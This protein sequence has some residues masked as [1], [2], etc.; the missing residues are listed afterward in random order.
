MAELLGLYQPANINSFIVAIVS[1]QGGITLN[2]PKTL[3][4][5]S[6]RLSEFKTKVAAVLSNFDFTISI[7]AATARD[8]YRKPRTGMWMELLEDSDLD[9]GDGPDLHKSF[10]VG[11]AAG[12]LAKPGTAAD[13]SS[14]DRYAITI[15]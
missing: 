4:T 3:K 15:L 6:K 1:N 7:Y 10:F 12:R 5:N 8:H 2:D 11:D 13:H 14:S 9:I